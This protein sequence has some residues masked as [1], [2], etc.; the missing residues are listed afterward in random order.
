[1]RRDLIRVEGQIVLKRVALMARNLHLKQLNH[2]IDGLKLGSI[3]HGRPH[4]FLDRT[5]TSTFMSRRGVIALKRCNPV[6]IV[7]KSIIL[8]LAILLIDARNVASTGLTTVTILIHDDQPVRLTLTLNK[9]VLVAV[10]LR[11]LVD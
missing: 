1:M 3:D 5:R 7:D 9:L 10:S 8:T 11:E 2:L 6:L 4:R